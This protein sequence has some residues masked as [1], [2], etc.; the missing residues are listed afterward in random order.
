MCKLC[1]QPPSIT[2]KWIHLVWFELDFHKMLI[3]IWARGGYCVVHLVYSIVC[4]CKGAVHKP[5]M[6]NRNWLKKFNWEKSQQLLSHRA[7]QSKINN[8]T[9]FFI[10]VTNQLQMSSIQIW[11]KNRKYVPSFG[12]YDDWTLHSELTPS[13]SIFTNWL[14]WVS[15]FKSVKK[16]AECET[17]G[18]G[19]QNNAFPSNLLTFKKEGDCE[20]RVQNDAF[21][22]SICHS[23][24]WREKPCDASLK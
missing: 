11:L 21:P 19:V 20:T 3:K 22:T 12:D 1:I 24:L 8:V 10:T 6:G 9:T 15:Q 2:G 13:A 16:E 17:W 14:N 18:A 23:C 5:L 7:P 4:G